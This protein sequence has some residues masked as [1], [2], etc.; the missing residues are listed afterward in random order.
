[1]ERRLDGR[2]PLVACAGGKAGISACCGASRVLQE[3]ASGNCGDS[4]A[5]FCNAVH[6]SQS[7]FTVGRARGLRCSWLARLYLR[8]HG[9]RRGV[10]QFVATGEAS[11]S[12]GERIFGVRIYWHLRFGSALGCWL[13]ELPHSDSTGG[14]HSNGS[15]DVR[16][17]FLNGRGVNE[18]G[19]FSGPRQK[20]RHCCLRPKWAA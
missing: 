3:A 4:L 7:Q 10:F 16:P 2:M 11:G 6:A 1:M 14:A 20:S 18:V 19:L 8:R 15:A 5:A 9:S 17:L 13:A 12:C